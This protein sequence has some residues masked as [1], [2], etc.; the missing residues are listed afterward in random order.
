MR[1]VMALFFFVLIFFL[2]I[3]LVLTGLTMG[4]SY[5]LTLVIPSLTMGDTLTAGAVIAISSLY[6]L[7]KLFQVIRED[8]WVDE[9]DDSQD[10]GR[11]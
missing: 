9:E 3:I 5:I 1:R 4:C 6:L 2:F 8:A 11:Q 7:R 10:S